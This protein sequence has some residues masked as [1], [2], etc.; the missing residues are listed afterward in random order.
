MLGHPF[1][2]RAG[3]EQNT[4]SRPISEHR[5]QALPRRRDAP[6]RHRAVFADDAQLAL[7]L[8]EIKPYRIHG[9]WPPRVC[10]VARR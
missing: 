8:V 5:S 2:L 9:G 1:T 10:P 6:F 7:A 4:G 3:P